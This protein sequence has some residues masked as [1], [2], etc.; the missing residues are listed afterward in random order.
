MVINIQD[1]ILR[2]HA[3]GLLDRLLADKAT[4][5]NILWA[6]DAYVA[7]SPGFEPGTRGLEI[8]CS[9]QLS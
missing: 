3:M 5:G 6:T 8:R 4:R 9:I 2:L 7:R 1:D